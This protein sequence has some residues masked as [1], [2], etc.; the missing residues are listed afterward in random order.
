MDTESIISAFSARCW[1][2]KC[3][4]ATLSGTSLIHSVGRITQSN[5]VRFNGHFH[6][7]RIIQPP[8]SV[9]RQFVAVE[10][11]GGW[12]N[13]TC[14]FTDQMSFN[15]QCQSTEWKHKTMTLTHSDTSCC[16]SDSPIPSPITSS[17]FDSP[18]CSSITPSHLPGP[19]LLSYLAFVFSF[20]LF[21]VSVPCATLSHLISFWVHVN[22]LYRILTHLN[23]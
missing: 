11:N 10:N 13:G 6:V 22:I 16:I 14:C 20:P 19:L 4:L 15:H 17:S 21:F 5:H 9:R 1:Q 7:N 2:S 23:S 12:L 18:L 3:A 8:H